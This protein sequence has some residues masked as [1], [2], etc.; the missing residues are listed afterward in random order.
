[1]WPCEHILNHSDLRASCTLQR[2]GKT[3]EAVHTFNCRL[4]HCMKEPRGRS[5]LPTR[6]LSDTC[7]LQDKKQP[8]VGLL[9]LQQFRPAP[10]T[11]CHSMS[12]AEVQS[13]TGYTCRFCSQ[14]SPSTQ[15]LE[16]GPAPPA[17][18]TQ[19]SPGTDRQHKAPGARRSLAKAAIPLV[20]IHKAGII[21]V[22]H[23]YTPWGLQE[24]REDVIPAGYVPAFPLLTIQTGTNKVKPQLCFLR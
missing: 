8:T 2:L 7:E 4:W 22:Q 3:F 18:Q 15:L 16:A 5:T 9:L 11:F 24:E 23:T 17:E 19:R 10:W 13:R 12:V 21:A 14:L 20:L 1:M 6:P